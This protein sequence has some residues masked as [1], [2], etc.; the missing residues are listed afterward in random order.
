VQRARTDEL[1][2]ALLA[3]EQLARADSEQARER[4]RF[5]AEA[6]T[7]LSSSLDYEATLTRLANLAVPEMSD[8]CIVYRLTDAGDMVRLT[9]AHADPA[10][11]AVADELQSGLRLNP[12]ANSGVP[13]VIRTGQPILHP[14][15][16]PA[17]VASDSSDPGAA[18]RISRELG[19]CSWMCVPLNARGRTIGAISFLSAESRRRFGEEDLAPA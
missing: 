17:L 6:S 10:G 15:A 18:E 19:I 5:L 8:W 9:I 1:R 16:D 7:I 13:W 11:K 4:L 2:E 14:D 12:T 3:S